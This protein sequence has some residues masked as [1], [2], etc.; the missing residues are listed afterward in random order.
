MC[1]SLSKNL[2]TIV[3]TDSG[4]NWQFSPVHELYEYQ[5]LFTGKVLVHCH[6]G[7]SRSAAVVLA[8]LMLK[9]EM[10]LLDAIKTLR[11]RRWI[12]PNDGFLNQLI[13]L[14]VQL[15]SSK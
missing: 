13:E 4:E 6:Q 14:N 15:Y 9:H 3:N 8:Y 2:R 11:E 5:L 7:R 10:T 1:L 12:W